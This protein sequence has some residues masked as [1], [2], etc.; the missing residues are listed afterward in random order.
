M[1]AAASSENS[2]I[3]RHCLTV[4][5][6][7]RNPGQN[8]LTLAFSNCKWSWSQ[9][10]QNCMNILLVSTLRFLDWFNLGLEV[11]HPS[12]SLE[13]GLNAP[14]TPGRLALL[15]IVLLLNNLKLI[16]TA[17][18]LLALLFRA[19]NWFTRL[20]YRVLVDSFMERG[21]F[22]SEWHQN[23]IGQYSPILWC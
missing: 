10:L 6:L 5:L 19:F 23:L 8:L 21:W 11:W 16:S 13:I 15:W 17:W 12:E 7:M 18:V 2:S 22:R 9:T 4:C 20:R 3:S 1:L 14:Q